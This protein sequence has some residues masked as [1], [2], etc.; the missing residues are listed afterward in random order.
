MLIN[1]PGS[2]HEINYQI[3]PAKAIQRKMVCSLIKEIQLK[4]GLINFRYI[5]MGAK[6]FADF[7]LMH[8]QFGIKK[9]LSIE[10][11]SES[12]LRYDFNK[13][14]GFIEMKYG[15]SYEILPQVENWNEQNNLVWLDYDGPFIDKV[16][17]DINTTVIN[18]HS[19]DMLLITVNSSV[20][21]EKKSDKQEKM[22]ENLGKY[23]DESISLNRYTNKQLPQVES[24]I[25]MKTVNKCL[26]EKKRLH[27]I[28][29]SAEQLLCIT[30][31]D[32]APMM[33]VAILFSETKLSKKISYLSLKKKMPFI[34]NSQEI[35]QLQVPSLTNKEIQFILKEM[36]INYDEYSPEKFNGIDI[37]EI[38]QFEAIYRYYPY[39]IESTFAT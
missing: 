12:Q 21:G 9:M 30:Y 24:E 1:M 34:S 11:Q 20:G 23:F 3:R 17:D 25:M 22:R 19:G 18:A 15:Y 36:P 2:D 7:V 14:L 6:F 13:P 39:Y 8:N 28:E 29:L 37:N 38:K 10:A 27:D 16:L 26:Y 32:S 31:Q 4:G 5:G 35:F 33:T